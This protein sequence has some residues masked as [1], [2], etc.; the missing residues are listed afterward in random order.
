MT[1]F[2]S[3]DASCLLAGI[4]SVG[5]IT[6]VCS[7]TLQ[8]C[9]WDVVQPTLGS[10]LPLHVFIFVSQ[11]SVQG[12][13]IRLL[14]GGPELLIFVSSAPRICRK[15]FSNF[16][17]LSAWLLGPYL[18]Q[19]SNSTYQ[20]APFSVPLQPFQFPRNSLSFSVSPNIKNLVY[21]ILASSQ[22]TSFSSKSCLLK[23]C[24]PQLLADFL[25]L[26][27]LIV[28]GR[29]VGLLQVTSLYSKTCLLI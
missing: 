24:I 1:I 6:T 13:L 3:R 22:R 18:L 28:F 12:I 11:L 16:Q 25:L 14:L 23:S 26:I 2:Y 29:S 27:F 17:P 10:C 21:R 5:D 15:L 20:Q 7:E 4:K 9:V 8:T 19:L